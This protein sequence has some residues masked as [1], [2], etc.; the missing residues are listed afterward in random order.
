MYFHIHLCHELPRVDA[1][2]PC[3]WFLQ[4]HRSCRPLSWKLGYRIW[5]SSIL[6]CLLASILDSSN[7]WNTAKLRDVLS[8]RLDPYQ[9]FQLFRQV[10]I[11]VYFFYIR[12]CVQLFEHYFSVCSFDRKYFWGTS[13]SKMSD[14]KTSFPV[15]WHSE[16]FGVKHLPF[17]IIPPLIHFN[18][19]SGE[20]PSSINTKQIFNVLNE[21]VSGFIFF[22][23][24]SDK[25]HNSENR[26]ERFPWNPTCFPA[27]DMS[28]QGNPK[29][30]QSAFGMSPAYTLLMSFAY[31]SPFLYFSFN[32]S[33]CLFLIGISSNTFR[34]SSV[35]KCIEM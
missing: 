24:L 14:N 26:L 2:N 28:W 30:Q 3:S 9:E 4:Q 20:I 27:T 23:E 31:H 32:I 29:H 35:S 1:C 13:P 11:L 18:E 5:L 7:L 16:I 10:K 21:K 22:F 8:H 15:L 19:Q 6:L 25:I 17:C 34:C 12:L 33:F